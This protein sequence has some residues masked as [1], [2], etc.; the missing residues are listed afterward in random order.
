MEYK[1]WRKAVFKRDNWTCVACKIRGGI[2]H[3][4]HIK[5]WSTHPHLRYEISNGQ[6]LCKKCHRAKTSEDLGV[7]KKVFHALKELVEEGLIARREVV[8]NGEIFYE[9][10]II[11]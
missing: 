8:I 11:S 10:K 9:Y 7:N 3:A 1:E 5:M 2:L 4:D 6:T